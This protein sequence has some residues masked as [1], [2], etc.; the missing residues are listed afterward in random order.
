MAL[1]HAPGQVPN[2][3]AAGDEQIYRVN[4]NAGHLYIRTVYVGQRTDTE[5]LG[6][7]TKSSPSRQDHIHH[8]LIPPRTTS[9]SRGLLCGQSGPSPTP[10]DS[11][12]LVPSLNSDRRHS[13][14]PNVPLNAFV[15]EGNCVP[16]EG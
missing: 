16:G 13:L 12:H 8:P 15:D 11:P 4:R 10:K 6:Q 3:Q 14:L 1:R 5:S 2:P 9:S 7:A